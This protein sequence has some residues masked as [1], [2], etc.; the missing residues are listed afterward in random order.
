M[1]MK[2]T[3]VLFVDDDAGFLEVVRNL[4]TAYSEGQWDVLVATDAARDIVL[5]SVEGLKAPLLTI[6]DSKHVAVGDEVYA[7]GNPRGLEGT[8]SAGIISS[9]RAVGDDSLL[10][11]TAPIS[12]GSSGGPG[13]PD[14][15]VPRRN[16]P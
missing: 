13:R 11:I 15:G 14:L 4:M 6:G 10:Q 16:A 5:L 8:F 12:P 3:T 1:A 9:I 2:H 7:V